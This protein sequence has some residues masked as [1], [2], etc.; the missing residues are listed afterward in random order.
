MIVVTYRP[1][2]TRCRIFFGKVATGGLL[3]DNAAFLASLVGSSIFDDVV[4]GEMEAWGLSKAIE[5]ASMDGLE[6]AWIVVKGICDWG[7]G[8][9]KGWQPLAA[10]SAADL[11]YSVLSCPGALPI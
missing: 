10:A 3:L 11:V 2:G 9:A 6:I 4:G 1:D 8:K 5:Q 7:L